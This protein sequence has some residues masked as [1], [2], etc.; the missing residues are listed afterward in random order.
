MN[1][2]KAKLAYIWLHRTKALGIATGI[3]AAIE[4]L[5]AQYGHEIPAKYRG[6]LLGIAGMITFC[7]GLYN[8]FRDV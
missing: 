4:N 3:G 1:W 2:L 6:I 5:C 7:I 8:T